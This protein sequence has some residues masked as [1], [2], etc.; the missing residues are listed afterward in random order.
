[1]SGYLPSVPG[2]NTVCICHMNIVYS[3]QKQTNLTNPLLQDISVFNGHDAIQLENWLVDIQTAADLMAE[4]RTKLAYEQIKKF[5]THLNH[6]SYHD[7]QILGQ[8][9]GFIAIKNL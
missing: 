5:N 7:R 9:Q 1:M 3:S 2:A 8:H 4:I 6:R